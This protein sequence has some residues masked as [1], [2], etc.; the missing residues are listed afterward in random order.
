MFDVINARRAKQARLPETPLEE[1][2]IIDSQPNSLVMFDPLKQIKQRARRELRK[3]LAT[4]V[5]VSGAG[6]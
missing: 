5:G 4:T 6:R 2:H 3:R 1:E